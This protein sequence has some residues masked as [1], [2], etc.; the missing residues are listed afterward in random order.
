MLKLPVSALNALQQGIL[1]AYKIRIH[2]QS[3]QDY[4][5]A[6][7]LKTV[8]SFRWSLSKSG[9]YEIT[10]GRI[11][12]MNTDYYF[13]RFFERELP[14][15]KRVELYMLIGDSETLLSSC[16]IRGW[17]LSGNSV[18]L[19]VNARI[20]L[21]PLALRTTSV[22]S[23][24]RDISVLKRIYGDHSNSRINCTPLDR[25]GYIYHASDIPMQSI[26]RVFV[27]R[28]P[29]TAGFTAYPAY[30]DETGKSIACVVFDEAQYD[31]TVS[32][33]GKGAIDLD[34]GALIENPA[35]F[36]EDVFLNLQGYDAASIDSVELDR[37]RAVCLKKD[38]KIAL[39]LDDSRVTI[40]TLLD[41][42]ALNTGAQWLL[43]D[44][45][46]IM[47]LKGVIST[48]TACFDFVEP[49]M[50]ADS[51][52]ITS[53]ELINEVTVNY[54]WNPADGQFMSSLTKH[55][56]L[57]KL[58]YGEAK[59]T[60]NL[61]MIQGTRQAEYLCDAILGTSSVP[62]LLTSFKHDFRSVHVEV[63]DTCTVTHQAGVGP[64]GFNKARAIVIGKDMDN[65]YTV[66]MERENALYTSE[67]LTLTQTAR[68]GTPGGFTMT[69][70]GNVRTFTFFVI[71][72][73]G[74]YG[75]PL[76]GAEITIG[77]VT[78]ITDRAGQVK[79]ILDSGRYSIKAEC[80]GY[81][82]S[83][84]QITI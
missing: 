37:F 77:G 9:Q 71:L 79:F 74:S 35:D 62:E 8:S 30:Q 2:F 3:P 45:K 11:T 27:G 76:E 64:A 63:G 32:I 83:V 56:P 84:T 12:L 10:N 60:F 54:A 66:R 43:S 75:E 19:D 73:D 58:I 5:E 42:L 41:E 15:N 59:Q 34:S 47:R 36:I 26:T 80:P 16:V 13:S 53:G 49:E 28:E 50:D 67:L 55:S 57:S 20:L 4:T 31:K 69:S 21:D 38:I 81:A 68:P 48:E 52:S 46:S 44:D 70:E 33:S 22:Y 72:S 14:D 40:K 82:S 61:K 51:F 6:D 65:N 23:S 39:V 78:E 7:N 25:D 29:Q 24:P 17:T 1:P 18:D